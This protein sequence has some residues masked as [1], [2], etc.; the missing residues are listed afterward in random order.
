MNRDPQSYAIIGAAMEVH[1]ELGAG[2]FEP[3]YQEA[4]AIEFAV[5]DIL[6]AREVLVPVSY[7]GWDLKSSYKADFICFG[8]IILEVK[9]LSEIPRFAEAQAINYLKAT[10]LNRA[11]IINFGATKLEYKR[12]VLNYRSQFESALEEPTDADFRGY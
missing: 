8:D 6:F 12:I 4:L 5:R 3:V 11:L 7:K 1:R 2:F 9:A 10:R